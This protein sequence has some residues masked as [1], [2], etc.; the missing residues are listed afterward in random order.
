MTQKREV[1][2]EQVGNVGWLFL[3]NVLDDFVA[4]V[5]VFNNFWNIFNLSELAIGLILFL[6]IWNLKFMSGHF[7]GSS[8]GELERI[9]DLLYLS[10]LT[11]EKFFLELWYLF[12]RSFLF[13]IV[14][15]RFKKISHF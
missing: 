7:P 4:S 2:S 13:F 3:R 8:L 14:R 11:S 15:I 1:A 5:F 10:K 6:G 12:N 9:W